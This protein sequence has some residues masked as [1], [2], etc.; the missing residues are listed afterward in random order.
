MGYARS[1]FPDFESY[2]RIFVVLDEKN[3]QLILKQHISGYI[4]YEISSG[5]YP[6]KDVSELVYTIG[7]HE[8][9]PKIE[10]DDI[11]MKTKPF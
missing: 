9:T 7:D 8:G 4:N 3:I 11:S 6:T 1:P 5:I 2:P 10:Y